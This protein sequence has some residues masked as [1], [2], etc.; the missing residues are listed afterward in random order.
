[1]ILSFEGSSPSTPSI[2]PFFLKQ[3]IPNNSFLINSF[4]LKQKTAAKTFGHVSKKNRRR[5]HICFTVPVIVT[6]DSLEH[7]LKHFVLP[8]IFLEL[9]E[10]ILKDP[11][12]V[13][14][15]SHSKEKS[16]HLFYKINNSKYILATD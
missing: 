3:K 15:E 14:E 10:R 16:Y 2:F 13:F 12:D 5:N 11:F 4:R 9:L 1:M 8:D 7:A 6:K